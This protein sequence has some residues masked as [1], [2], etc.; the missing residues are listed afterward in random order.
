M[1]LIT[2]ALQFLTLL[3]IFTSQDIPKI[4]IYIESL[5]PYCA[6]LIVNTYK[7]FN[8][9][10]DK[11]KLANVTFYPYGNANESMDGSKRVFTC[12]HGPNE[13][14]GNTILACAQKQNESLSFNTFIICFEEQA[15]TNGKDFDAAAKK[16]LSEDLSE[17]V[18]KCAN[19]EEGSNALHEVAQLTPEHKYVPWIVYNGKHDD[20]IQNQIATDMLGFLCKDRSDF[21]GCKKSNVDRYARWRRH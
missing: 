21:E 20:T 2:F 6:K 5:C 10:Q 8:A 12:Q 13:C 17:S 11:N 3:P 7:V 9:N 19:S 15:W 18:L 16:C 4:D 14:Y 1:K